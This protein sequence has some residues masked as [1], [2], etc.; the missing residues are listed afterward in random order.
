[1]AVRLSLLLLVMPVG[2]AVF[3]QHGYTF[4]EHEALSSKSV[5]QDGASGWWWVQEG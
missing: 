4:R 5:L 3:P 1:V 2:A